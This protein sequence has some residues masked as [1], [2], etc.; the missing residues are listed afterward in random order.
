MTMARLHRTYLYA[1]G[2]RPEVM[3]KAASSGADAV[4]LDLEDSVAA[5]DKVSARQNIAGLLSG[6]G[7]AEA[8]ADIHVRINRDENG[9][10]TND[11]QAVVSPG[12]SALRLPKTTTG[13]EIAA[14]DALLAECEAAA[15]MAVGTVDL[16]PTIE[17]A[18]GVFAIEDFADASTRVARVAFGSTDFLADIGGSESIAADAP[19]PFVATGTAR[20]LLVLLSRAAGL[21][22]PIDSVHTV[23]A[24][25]EGCR[26]AAARARSMGFFGKSIIH[27][28]QIAPSHEAFTPTGAEI[29]WAHRVLAALDTAATDSTD[30]GR[31]VAVVDGEFVDAAVVA[32]AHGLL[33]FVPTATVPTATVPTSSEATEE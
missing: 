31:G 1:P 17:S 13:D 3:I 9:Y 19:D 11:V 2:T 22:P 7:F 25:I 12:L 21:G 24:D 27:P 15:G 26:I 28:R 30:G 8:T 18:A 4:I 33:Q 20:G 10:D 6:G 29:A 5:A 14:L 23:L 16:Y 32:R